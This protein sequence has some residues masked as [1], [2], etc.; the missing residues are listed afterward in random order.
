LDR[1]AQ[2]YAGQIKIA[3]VNVDENPN[4]SGRYQVTGIPQLLMFK[5]GKVVGK[6]VGAHPQGNIEQLIKQ[7]L[8]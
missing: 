5:S 7:A 2:Q 1:L 3:K 4:L 8:H 6:L